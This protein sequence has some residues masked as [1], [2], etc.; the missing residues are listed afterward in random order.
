MNRRLIIA[1]SIVLLFGTQMV[2]A[3]TDDA[4]VPGSIR[5]NRY[6]LESVR[7]TNLAER[8]YA[9]G[10]YDASTRYSEEAVRYAEMSDG[11]VSRQL[12]I[13]ETDEAIAAA[14]RRLDYADSVDAA[15]RHTEEYTEAQAAYAEA[16]T[17]RSAEQ[18]DNAISSAN[19]VLVSLAYIGGDTLVRGGDSG[20][21]S[22]SDSGRAV[23]LPAQYTV[24]TWSTTRDCFW[25]IAGRSWAYNDPWKW[26]II[27]EA[28]K[29]KLPEAGNP[30]L[31]HPGTV[32][33]IP[34]IRGETR[35]G[36]FDSNITYQA[37]P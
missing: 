19:R 11:Y 33:D 23:T 26:R 4:E 31:I 24:R 13:R 18:W 34:S 35:Q 16:R 7:L 9:D 1:S 22:R 37:I 2:F 5:N 8:A 6:F 12:K 29:D 36:T 10:D 14:R 3:V 30:D 32:L 20:S 21:G 25:N 27:Y 17:Y 28:N 15:S